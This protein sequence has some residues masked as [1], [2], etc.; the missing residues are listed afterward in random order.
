MKQ[1]GQIF[2]L[3]KLECALDAEFDF[4]TWLPYCQRDVEICVAILRHT[5]PLIEKTTFDCLAQTYGLADIAFNISIQCIQSELRCTLN[6]DLKFIYDYSKY[7]GR[8][9]SSINGQQ[10]SMPVSVI[11]ANSMY[12]S[13]MTYDYPCGDIYVVFNE[14]IAGRLAIYYVV[15]SKPFTSCLDA[16]S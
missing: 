15:L 9:Y 3:P 13:C 14:C 2:D 16:V 7:G 5:L 10:I 11:D 4:T 6:S 12:P 1:I 8:T